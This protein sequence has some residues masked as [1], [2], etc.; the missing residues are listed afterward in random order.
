MEWIDSQ[1]QVEYFFCISFISADTM[2]V[3]FSTFASITLN[4]KT[5]GKIKA[6][7]TFQFVQININNKHTH[8]EIW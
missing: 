4:S 1:E 5:D 6:F 3:F 7:F 2:S 8:L